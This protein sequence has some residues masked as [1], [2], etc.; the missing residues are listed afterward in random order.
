M[1]FPMEKQAI[2]PRCNVRVLV[3]RELLGEPFPCPKCG[4]VFGMPGLLRR[5]V[6]AFLMLAAVPAFFLHFAL[7]GGVP[8][9]FGVPLGLACAAGIGALAW[10]A[11]RPWFR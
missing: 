7:F 5:E 1:L 2:C 9:A 6:A 4:K 8:P 3:P 10:Y 11:F